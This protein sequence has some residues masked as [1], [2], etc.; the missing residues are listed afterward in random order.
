MLS[1]DLLVCNA[2]ETISYQ[3]SANNQLDLQAVPTKNMQPRAEEASEAVAFNSP[4]P[5]FMKV[6]MS[7]NVGGSFTL[8]RTFAYTFLNLSF[9]KTYYAFFSSFCCST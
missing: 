3:T 2:G 7:S 5:S 1:D 4:F 6:M 9:S 8:V